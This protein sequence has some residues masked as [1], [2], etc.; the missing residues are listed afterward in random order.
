MGI[1]TRILILI[2]IIFIAL[3]ILGWINIRI[4]EKVGKSESL[5]SKETL[6]LRYFENLKEAIEALQGDLISFETENLPSMILKRDIASLESSLKILR[7]L[8]G[9]DRELER[10][11]SMLL[12]SIETLT[13]FPAKGF[14]NFCLSLTSDTLKILNER[15]KDKEGTI[16]RIR[17]EF[18]KTLKKAHR[19]SIV[20]FVLALIITII[21]SIMAIN[22]IKSCMN[23][24]IGYLTGITRQIGANRFP[25]KPPPVKKESPEIKGIIKFIERLVSELNQSVERLK[26]LSKAKTAFLAIVSHELRTPLTPII[27]FSELLLREDISEEIKESLRIIASEARKLSKMIERMLSYSRLDSEPEMREIS[28]KSLLADEAGTIKELAERKKLRFILKLPKED[29]IVKTDP[30]RLALA[31]REILNNALKFTKEGYIKLSLKVADESAI[32]A[33]E[34]TGIGIEKD[35]EKVIFELFTQSENFLRRQHEGI[36]IGLPLA[37]RAIKSIGGN[38]YFK[39][40]PGKGSRFFIEIPLKGG[41]GLDKDR[42]KNAGDRTFGNA[43]DNG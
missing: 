29:I 15:I 23:T 7:E 42:P 17:V 39:S 37:L 13:E 4:I 43:S 35:K 3:F 40:T 30:S 2:T 31:L 18:K 11:T 10:A 32:I 12:N 36:G 21:S 14:L 16:A 20:I 38:I 19:D 8:S 33:I 26:E 27:G 25:V 24:L 41:E 34:D 1:K 9:T 6:I 22:G 28:L 5:F